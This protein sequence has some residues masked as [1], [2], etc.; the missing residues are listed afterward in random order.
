MATLKVQRPKGT[1]D[2]VPSQMYKWNTVEGIVK[3]TASA[4]G[5]R[6]IRIPTFEDTALFVRSVGDTTDV[7]QKEMYSVTAKGDADFS[8]RPEGTAGTIRALI[9]NGIL[10]EGFPQKVFYVLS[11]FRHEKPQAGRLREFHQFGVEMAGTK[12]PRADAEVI[13]LAKSIIDTA[14]LR[15]I[16]L[17]INSIGCPEC[18]AKYHAALKE[19]F[20]GRA[21]ELCDTCRGRLEKNP[22]RILDCKSPVCSEI[23]EGAP[24]ILDYLCEDCREHFEKLQQYLTAMD[25]KFEINPKIVR[26]LDYYTKTVFEFVT[27][28]IGAQGTVCGGGRYDGLIETLSGKPCPALGFAMGLERLILTMEKQGLD[29]AA[30]DTCDIY[31]ASMGDAASVKAMQMCAELRA[32]GV[33]AEC[34]VVGRGLKAQ[35]K[36]ADKLGAK[37]SVVL[38]DSELESQTAELKN[39][40]TGEKVTLPI[41]ERFKAAFNAMLISHMLSAEEIEEPFDELESGD[42]TD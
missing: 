42:I 19:Y 12:D 30:E 25:I 3:D 32:D 37:F 18:R 14:G 9:E 35:M 38:G 29:F 4:Y 10:N 13:S 36:Y 27:T 2:V 8:L 1:Q 15:G 16:K 11:C 41:D 39:M 17:F 24:V 33:S 5:F 26:G 28:D 23:A 40:Q 34:D 6:E 22:M 31:I 20:A 7:V 21:D